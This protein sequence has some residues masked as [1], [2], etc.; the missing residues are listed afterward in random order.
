[1]Q[2][3]RGEGAE[4]GGCDG[5]AVAAERVPS[6]APKDATQVHVVLRP[7]H[8]EEGVLNCWCCSQLLVHGVI[9]EQIELV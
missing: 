2:E 8:F 5:Q 6:G 7:A 9:K 1:M 3:R 4:C